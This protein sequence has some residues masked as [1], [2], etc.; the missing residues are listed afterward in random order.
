MRGA[1]VDSVSGIR[2]VRALAELVRVRLVLRLFPAA[3]VAAAVR[4][5]ARAPADSEADPLTLAAF[6]RAARQPWLRLTCLPRAIALKRLLVRQGCDARLVIALARQDPPVGHAW[7]EVDGRPLLE[8]D[9]VAVR[10]GFRLR[11]E[12]LREHA[13]LSSARIDFGERVVS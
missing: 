5:E 7:V 8:A 1:R 6:S 10:Y 2:Y 3:T 9:D 11:D 4:L 13:F 12:T